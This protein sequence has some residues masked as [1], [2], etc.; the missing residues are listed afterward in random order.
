MARK[1]KRLIHATFPRQHHKSNI[2]ANGSWQVTG[3]FHLP[4]TQYGAATGD[5]EQVMPHGI[6]RTFFVYLRIINTQK[7]RSYA[8]TSS[9]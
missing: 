5:D 7:T 8:S 1:G 3:G 4:P 9:T 2:R 6:N